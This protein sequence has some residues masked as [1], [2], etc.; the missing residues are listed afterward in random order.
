MTISIYIYPQLDIYI[1]KDIHTNY[2]NPTKKIDE[3]LVSNKKITVE[4]LQKFEQ[5]N[6]RNQGTEQAEFWFRCKDLRCGG[7]GE[8]LIA[9]EGL[10][11]STG[12][13]VE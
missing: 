8:V 4:V 11:S 5:E 12:A 3:V 9:H 6:Y 7:V 1:H 2:R 13:A 10:E